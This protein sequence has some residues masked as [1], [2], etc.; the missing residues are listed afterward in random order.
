MISGTL[1]VMVWVCLLVWA[2]DQW[3]WIRIMS[4]CR[5]TNRQSKTLGNPNFP[6]Q[7]RT[8]TQ[9][10]LLVIPPCSLFF[11]SPMLSLHVPA[12]WYLTSKPMWL[13]ICPETFSITL[14][15]KEIKYALLRFIH[16]LTI[17]SG[18]MTCILTAFPKP[19]LLFIHLRILFSWL[20][21]SKC[22]MSSTD[23]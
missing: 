11:L 22:V 14:V 7:L 17:F 19:I 3:L 12:H 16:F 10:H 6:V 21:P 2:A 5:L 20:H 8:P 4:F 18:F 13:K 1:Q 15:T 23:F 9:M